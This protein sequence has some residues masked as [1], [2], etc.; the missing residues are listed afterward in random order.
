MS[1]G[2]KSISR[3]S[4]VIFGEQLLLGRM[5]NMCRIFNSGLVILSRMVAVWQFMVSGSRHN[6]A[7]SDHGLLN[8][9]PTIHTPIFVIS[10]HYQLLSYYT[11]PHLCYF[12]SLL[13]YTPPPPFRRTESFPLAFKTNS[14]NFV[15]S[16]FLLSQ[17][18]SRDA[19]TDDGETF[20]CVIS[21]I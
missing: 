10:F 2:F 15:I 16:R 12:I 1:F 14:L 21:E 19:L 8:Y 5:Y 3:T 18:A 9:S 20:N 11:Y 7:I 4:N 13:G 6:R 17:G